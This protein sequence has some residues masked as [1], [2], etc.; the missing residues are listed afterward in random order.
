M[1]KLF[2]MILIL[3]AI[4]AAVG[5][6]LYQKPVESLESKKPDII[7]DAAK[8]ISDY[9]ADEQ[10]AN[11][12]YLGKIV[13]VNGKIATVS[14]ENGKNKIQ[15]ETPNPIS[16]I[17]CE[18]EDGIDVSILQPGEQATLKGVCSGYLSDVILVQ[19]TIVK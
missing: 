12:T 10:K 3:G 1:R 6:Y 17:I 5:F 16:M 4:G 7:A 8:L 18:M 9:E 14:T 19:C 2:I 11:D 15:L 13:Q